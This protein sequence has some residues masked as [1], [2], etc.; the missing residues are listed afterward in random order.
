MLCGILGFWKRPQKWKKGVH[1]EIILDTPTTDY[2]AK[3]IKCFKIILRHFL[4]KSTL[5][6]QLHNPSLLMLIKI[7]A[8][9]SIAA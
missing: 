8:N 5:L 7:K 2:Y 3:P 1:G 6:F 4:T 9:Y